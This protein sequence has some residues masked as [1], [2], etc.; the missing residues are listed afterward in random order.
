VLATRWVGLP[1]IE[2]QH[3]WLGTASL[4]ILGHAPS[5]PD[6]RVL[7]LWNATPAALPAHA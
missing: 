4:S 1:V 5:H 3:L 6:V 2:G 7:A